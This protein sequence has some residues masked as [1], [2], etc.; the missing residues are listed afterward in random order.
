MQIPMSLLE[1]IGAIGLDG[2]RWQVATLISVR[3]NN[4]LDDMKFRGEITEQQKKDA[5][6]YIFRRDRD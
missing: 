2:N 5:I 1:D 3:I 4:L 6:A